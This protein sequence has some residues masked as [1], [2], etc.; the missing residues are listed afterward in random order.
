MICKILDHLLPPPTG[1]HHYHLHSNSLQSMEKCYVWTQLFTLTC[2]LSPNYQVVII[3][4]SCVLTGTICQL[5]QFA[6][7]DRILLLINKLVLAKYLT[8]SW[9]EIIWW[10]ML[11]GGFTTFPQIFDWKQPN[12]VVMDVS[13]FM[14]WKC[15]TTVTQYGRG[16]PW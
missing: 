11:L 10:M 8:N 13:Q 3:T 4:P 6:R 7:R 5:L 9:S 16:T 1:G 14:H 15:C 12:K 2:I